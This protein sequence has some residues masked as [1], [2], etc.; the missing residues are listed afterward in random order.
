[1]VMM[2]VLAVNHASMYHALT[3]ITSIRNPL[4]QT[5]G[6]ATKAM[7]AKQKPSNYGVKKNET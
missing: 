1:M 2:R 5:N 3:V 7:D 4:T 6:Y